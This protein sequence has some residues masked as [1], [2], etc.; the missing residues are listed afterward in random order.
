MTPVPSHPDRRP[1]ALALLLIT[2]LP[3]MA[4]ASIGNVSSAVGAASTAA[5]AIASQSG[6]A[7][8]PVGNTGG[9]QSSAR[10]QT[11]GAAYL[12]FEGETPWLV[13]LSSDDAYAA[14]TPDSMTYVNI[15]KLQSDL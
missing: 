12:D 5:A 4:C 11:I 6:S 14:N 1:A 2:S 13:A 9:A 8:T 3:V 10:C 7:A 15:P